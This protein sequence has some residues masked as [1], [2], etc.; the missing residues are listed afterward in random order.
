M[1]DVHVDDEVRE[2]EGADVTV[3]IRAGFLRVV[4]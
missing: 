1:D 3:T 4:G 2:G